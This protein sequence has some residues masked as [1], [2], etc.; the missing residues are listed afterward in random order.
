MVVMD[1]ALT[2]PPTAKSVAETTLTSKR[3][4]DE[5]PTLIPKRAAAALGSTART[6]IGSTK[7]AAVVNPLAMVR[8]A[9][10]LISK[11]VV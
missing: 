4:D 6:G 10:N 11:R 2:V 7:G 5:P 1:E 8:R 9:R 3:G